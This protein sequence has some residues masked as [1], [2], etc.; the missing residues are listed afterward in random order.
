M[1]ADL[2][3][4]N[5]LQLLPKYDRANMA[6]SGDTLDGAIE[7]GLLEL[8]NERLTPLQEKV[9]KVIVSADSLINS[10]NEV[11]NPEYPTKS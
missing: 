4:V 8:V 10:F 7:E 11:M 5:L 3:V 1:V 6:K 9:E 2:L